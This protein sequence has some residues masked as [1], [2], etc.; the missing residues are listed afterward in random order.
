MTVLIVRKP[1]RLWSA[2]ART[3]ARL[4]GQI[5]SKMRLGRGDTARPASLCGNAL[6][7]LRETLSLV[8]KRYYTPLV[9]WAVSM[10][11]AAAAIVLLAA[12]GPSAAPELIVPDGE[13]FILD[14]ES[15]RLA[16]VDAPEKLKPHCAA[17]AVVGATSRDRLASLLIPSYLHG[18]LALDRHGTDALGRT[19]ALVSV[20]GRDVGEILMEEGLAKPWR[21]VP[22]EWCG[23]GAA[24]A[25]PVP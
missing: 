8:A 19:L 17:E 7:A 10:G 6:G 24:G 16:N 20:K 12:S 13:T 1:E 11:I 25:I 23:E 14:G 22:A 3:M 2:E 21:A 18:G 15:F 5:M 4:A 9:R